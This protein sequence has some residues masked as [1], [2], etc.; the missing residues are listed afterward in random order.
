MLFGVLVLIAAATDV[1]AE[2]ADPEIVTCTALKADVVLTDLSKSM[3]DHHGS[4]KEV[5]SNTKRSNDQSDKSD[6]TCTRDTQALI[7]TEQDS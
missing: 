5:R 3:S 6:Q 2:E 4:T 1:A 7:C